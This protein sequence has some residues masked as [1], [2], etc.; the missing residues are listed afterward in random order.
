MDIYKLPTSRSKF[1]EVRRWWRE[2]MKLRH[3]AW[4][5][6]IKKMYMGAFKGEDK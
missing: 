4:D 6:E 1:E 3:E 5:R 2:L